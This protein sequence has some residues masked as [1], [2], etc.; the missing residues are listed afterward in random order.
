MRDS[1]DALEQ[2]FHKCGHATVYY[3]QE[4]KRSIDIE[5]ECRDYLHEADSAVLFA[6]VL[7]HSGDAADAAD[8]HKGLELAKGVLGE[9][10]NNCSDDPNIEAAAKAQLTA[11]PNPVTLE[12]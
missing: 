1:H 9:I 8:A 5:A 11:L 7:R 4:G 10:I 12:P 2:A 6:Y 3:T